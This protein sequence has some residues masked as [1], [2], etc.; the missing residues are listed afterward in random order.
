[1]YT[2]MNFSNWSRGLSVMRI[3]QSEVYGKIRVI[4]SGIVTNLYFFDE[5]KI[6]YRENNSTRFLGFLGKI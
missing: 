6:L 3:E 4:K 1:M 5:F 2:L